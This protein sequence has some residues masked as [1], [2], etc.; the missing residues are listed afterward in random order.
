MN[1]QRKLSYGSL[2][3]NNKITNKGDTT[4]KDFWKDC[5][6]S[7]TVVLMALLMGGCIGITLVQH[8]Y[9]KLDPPSGSS[10]D[11]TDA[12]SS[13]V[14]EVSSSSIEK[15]KI[16]MPER[17]SN[18]SASMVWLEVI[19]TPVFKGCKASTV[20]QEIYHATDI[21]IFCETPRKIT[22]NIKQFK[23]YNVVIKNNQMY[24]TYSCNWED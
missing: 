1:C 18:E 3:F 2:T 14:E 15:K 11:I 12:S 13:S 22:E 7:L 21:Q 9:I 24:I 4:M 6:V 10:S 17:C 23:R 5:A 16:K 20:E 19:N 8:G